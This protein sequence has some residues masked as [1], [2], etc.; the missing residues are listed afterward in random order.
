MDS[1]SGIIKSIGSA[2]KSIMGKEATTGSLFIDS[3]KDPKKFKISFVNTSLRRA[4]DSFDL[5]HKRNALLVYYETSD[6]ARVNVEPYLLEAH[7]ATIERN[8]AFV[9]VTPQSSEIPI[10]QQY[11]DSGIFPV[12]LAFSY[13][14]IGDLIMMEKL[15]LS[16][17]VLKDGKTVAAFLKRTADAANKEE[18]TYQQALKSM[19][20]KTQ[21]NYHPPHD[22][23]D[24]DDYPHDDVPAY[25]PRPNYTPDRQLKNDQDKDYERTILEAQRKKEEEALRVAQEQQIEREKA[26][27]K[28][29]M[30]EFKNQLA[31]Q[32]I[33][34]AH[35]ITL[36]LRFP[37]GDKISKEFDRRWKVEV[38]QTFAATHE[39][40][41]ESLP[42]NFVLK[43]GFPPAA[44]DQNKILE[45]CFPGSDAEQVIVSEI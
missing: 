32:S 25:P 5:T 31:S 3:L 28:R 14:G 42:V 38:V 24:A 6:K 10:I 44:L 11:L 33:D 43:A 26:E 7:G 13:N 30:E 41:F 23:D 18:D 21:A 29:K 35:S 1:G 16:P 27:K 15:V 12:L 39:E 8:F 45:D 19:F 9:G 20:A 4:L 36:Q 37:K 40:L 17:E 34:P 2:F 22:F